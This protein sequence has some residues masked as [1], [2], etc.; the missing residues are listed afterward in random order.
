MI[1]QYLNLFDLKVKDSVPERLSAWMVKSA[2]Q[3]RGRKSANFVAWLEMD[4]ATLDA[5]HSKLMRGGFRYV[6]HSSS[7]CGRLGA[8]KGV[9]IK[10][11]DI[12]FGCV[13]A[14]IKPYKRIDPDLYRGVEEIPLSLPHGPL[15]PQL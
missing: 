13:A 1:K 6:R 12:E 7:P 2:R 10:E 14:V 5:I 11:G 8:F 9:M 4:K 3:R 15:W